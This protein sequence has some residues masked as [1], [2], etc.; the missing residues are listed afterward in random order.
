MIQKL[1]LLLLV[2]TVTQLNGQTHTEKINKEF[3]F[4]KKSTE[5]TLIIAKIN[6]KIKVQSY[7]GDKIIV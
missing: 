2:C 1:V 6:C 4:E 7:E 3:T 5:N